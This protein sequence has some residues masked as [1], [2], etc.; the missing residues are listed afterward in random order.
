MLDSVQKVVPEQARVYI[1]EVFAVLPQTARELLEALM[2]TKNREYKSEFARRYYGEGEAKGEAKAVL[3]VL[4]T[5]GIDVP[6]DVR[7]RISECSDIEQL[8]SWVVRA[9]TVDSVDDLFA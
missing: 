1:D 4:A 7:V 2:E 5:R 6:E 9:V 3:A 8:E